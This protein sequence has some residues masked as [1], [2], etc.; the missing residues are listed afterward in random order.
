MSSADVIFVSEQ[1]ANGLDAAHTAG[2]LHR[3][4]KPDNIFLLTDGTV[5]LFDFGLAGW[6]ASGN[7][8]S[9]IA[10]LTMDGTVC[11]TVGY[12]SPEQ[13]S[14]SKCDE[15]SDIFALGG[16]MYEM[17][18][19]RQPFRRRTARESIRA[20]LTFEPEPLSSLVPDVSLPLARLVGEYLRKDPNAR[21]QN[22]RTVS[23]HLR[24]LRDP[25]TKL[26]TVE[27]T[28]AT[29]LRILV[30]DDDSAVRRTVRSMAERDGH[31]VTAVDSWIGLNHALRDRVFDCILMD[32]TL[33]SIKGYRL[34][35]VLKDDH[36]LPTMSMVLMSQMSLA[37]LE[38][39][40]RS[41][42]A[43][44]LLHKPFN[45]LDLYAV[46]QR[47]RMDSEEDV[48]RRALQMSGSDARTPVKPKNSAL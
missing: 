33:P 44:G 42:N 21:V 39:R 43:D 26:D 18:S 13:A 8:P 32:D 27:N 45:A 23:D 6:R 24:S 5:K 3:D 1:L 17:L 47:V 28:T 25:G 7:M 36:R 2:I 30:V 29:G 31:A 46:L 20:T 15:R 16:V 35:E 10:P 37:Q 12:M 14:G 34:I 22:A 4:L 48:G 11:G 38:E 41:C 9:P 19:G 40:A